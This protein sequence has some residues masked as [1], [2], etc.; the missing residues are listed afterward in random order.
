MACRF[1]KMKQQHKEKEKIDFG[2]ERQDGQPQQP[3]GAP[4]GGGSKDAR[5]KMDMFRKG[6]LSGYCGGLVTVVVVEVVVDDVVV[7]VVVVEVA[8]AEVCLVIIVKWA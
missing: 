3:S 4:Q 1:D 7:S 5:P 8:G 2:S 6:L